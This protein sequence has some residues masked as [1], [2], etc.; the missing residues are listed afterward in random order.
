MKIISLETTYLG[1]L[2][3]IILVG[4]VSS[5]WVGTH[6][7]TT[8]FEKNS[9]GQRGQIVFK[10]FNLSIQLVALYHLIQVKT[11]M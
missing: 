6:R 7:E 4:T 8:M 5:Y 9:H 2:F 10:S 11:E 3:S 1:G